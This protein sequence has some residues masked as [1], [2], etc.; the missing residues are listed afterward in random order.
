MDFFKRIGGNIKDAFT[1]DSPVVVN[2]NYNP[3]DQSSNRYVDRSQLSLSANPVDTKLESLTG[4]NTISQMLQSSMSNSLNTPV[5]PAFSNAFSGMSIGANGQLQGTPTRATAPTPTSVN[6]PAP[7]PTPT[8]SPV[9][10]VQQSVP[11][12][13]T[14]DPA[15]TGQAI[16]PDRLSPDELADLARKAGQSGMSL[17]EYTNLVNANAG[18]GSV[19]SA[20][21]R[22][23]L[24][25]DALTNQVFAVPQ[26]TTEDIYD[27]LYKESGIS[28]LKK[29]ISG[30]DDVIN[31]KRD[32]FVKVE[33]EIKGNP[34]LS[35]ASRRGRLANAADLALADISNDINERQQLLDR[36]N[37]GVTQ[38]ENSLT[39]VISDRNLERELNTNRL[40]YL[41]NEAERREG[42]QVTDRVSEGLR[43]V[44]D[45]LDARRDEQ[46]RIEAN[47]RAD[48]A[49]QI[50]ANAVEVPVLR[51]D[52]AGNTIAGTAPPK[53]P[54]QGE[55]SSLLFFQRMADAVTNLDELEA[56]IAK[57]GLIGQAQMAA[58][59]MPLLLTQNQERY[60]Q[61]QRTF[62]EARLRRDSGAAIPPEE[63]ANDRLTYFP[64]PG[65]TAD[66][67]AQK[68]QSRQVALNGLRVASANAYWDLYGVNPIEETIARVSGQ[69]NASAGGAQPTAADNSYVSGLNLN[70]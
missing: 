49:A 16:D 20:A 14:Y 41:L 34:W 31:Q 26:E 56:G 36:Y 28:S 13:T 15:I 37:S 69:Q 12:T 59:D 10:T 23:D 29:D 44:P 35:S 68:A 51:L 47:E 7:A 22:E 48:A 57:T 65:D 39:R 6:N 45:F 61:A 70:R 1:S 63:F 21:I 38:I 24:G 8:R 32:D 5:N 64:Q 54:T 9:A 66:T 46:L 60:E 58:F 67:L 52:E 11:S 55:R 27:R 4:K 18:L 17:S 25:V 53:A 42:L 50:A 62:T 3:N 33:G 30:I 2:S 19:D 40:N 43:N